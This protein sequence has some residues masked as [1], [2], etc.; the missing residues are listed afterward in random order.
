MK[1]EETSLTED[2]KRIYRKACDMLADGI[3]A[4][5]FSERI[6]GPQGE[7]GRLGQTKKDRERILKSKLHQWLKAKYE[8]L[9]LRGAAQFEQDLKRASG[10]LTVMVPRSLHAALKDEAASEGV[11]LS[12]LIRLKLSISYRQMTDLLVPK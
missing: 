10:R 3:D 9:R 12:E 8:D 11:S 7:L 2:E 1:I 4:P 6:F 5:A